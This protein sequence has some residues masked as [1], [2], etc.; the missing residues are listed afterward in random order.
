MTATAT[1]A[2]S[3]LCDLE[4]VEA[5]RRIGSK[6]IS[7]VELLESCI[8]RIEAVDGRLNAVVTRAFERARDEAKT[9]ERMVMAG[10]P[11]GLLHGLPVG[12]K[13]LEA[14]GGIRTTYG[15]LIYKDNVPADDQ[16][17]VAA[18]RAEGAIVVGKTNTPEFG[19]GANTKNRVFGATGNPFDPDKTCAGS[20]GGSA[21]ALAT[22]MVSLASG[23]DYGGSLRTPAGF[24]GVVGFRP[25][26]GTVP[27]EGRAAALMPWGVLGP[28][29]RTVKDLALMLQAQLGEDRRDPF[30]GV[31]DSRLFDPVD[32]LDLGSVRAA[33]SP[34]LG[35]C[36]VDDGIRATFKARSE[37]FQGAFAEGQD[38]A[39][40][41][42]TALAGS[43]GDVHKVF[44]VF[45]GMSFVASHQDRL[46]DHKDLLDENVIDNTT[47]GFDWTMADVGW[48]L[49]QQGKM[50]RCF[51][52]LF[53]EVDVLICPAASVSPFP[54]KQLF[55]DEINGDKMPTYM[56]WLALSYVPTTALA[57]ACVIPAGVDH[58][59]MPFGIQIIGPSGA[60]ARVLAVAYALERYFQGIPDLHRPL[61]DLAALKG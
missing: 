59:G 12:I 47:R 29:G 13:D 37:L 9:A 2:T 41:F 33:I 6:E 4:A 61:P 51:A 50:V 18:V 7:P 34:D 32:G 36:P 22:G 38:R 15:S 25:S 8:A 23:S 48:A 49:V 40:A 5:R 17:S 10:E 57:C 20:S 44:E 45:R 26:V 19:A 52:D 11:L 46:R 43:G 56:R 53:D 60:D 27:A 58:L 28:M 31:I 42:D 35:C 3:E 39:P 1:D 21:V 24:C 30:S 54:H 16:G 55:V 14:T